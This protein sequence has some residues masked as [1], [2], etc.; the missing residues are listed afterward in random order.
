MHHLCTQHTRTRMFL[1]I[2]LQ[3]LVEDLLPVAADWLNLGL[4]LGIGVTKLDTIPRLEDTAVECF[5]LTL[6]EWLKS[7]TATH[8]AV[9]DALRSSVI[10][11]NQLA[12]QLD[13][14]GL[15]YSNHI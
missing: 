13:T 5:R 14:N 15:C 3:E 8:G 11:H 10:G 2:G 4:Q 9:I 1:A 6:T 7:G 12:H